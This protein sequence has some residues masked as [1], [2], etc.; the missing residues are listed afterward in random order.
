MS[1]PNGIC[2]F[3]LSNVFFHCRICV[4]HCRLQMRDIRMRTISMYDTN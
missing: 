3:W 1:K 4:F 2:V